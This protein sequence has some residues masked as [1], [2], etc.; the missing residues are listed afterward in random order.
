[1]VELDEFKA[2]LN[3]YTKPL[4]EV[5]IHFDLVNKEQRIQELEREMEAPGFWDNPEKS[6]ESMKTLKSLKDDVAVYQQLKDQY[7]EIELLQEMGYE[8]NDPEVIPEIQ[9]TLDSFRATFDAVRIKTL[10]SGEYDRANAIVTLHAGGRRNRVLRLGFH[11][12][13]DVLPLGR[14]KRISAGSAG[15]SGRR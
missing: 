15:L 3:S 1:M 4:V 6:Q 5:R 7:E 14:Q 9:E 2:I 10:L 12:L 11:A 8:E 13:P